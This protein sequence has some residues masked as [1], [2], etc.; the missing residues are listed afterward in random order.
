MFV[1]SKLYEQGKARGLRKQ[2]WALRKI[3]AELDVALSSVSVWVRDIPREPRR[4]HVVRLRRLS[5]AVQRCGRCRRFLPVEL[6]NKHRSN[7]RQ[8]W[9]RECFGGYFRAR[10]ALHRRQVKSSRQRRTQLA[11]DHVLKQLQ[12]APCAD[13]G[14]RDLVVLDYDHVRGDKVDDISRLINAGV[15]L[16]MLDEEIAKCEVVCANCHRLRTAERA[17]TWRSRWMRRETIENAQRPAWARNLNYVGA[18]LEL[19]GCVDCA[20]SDVRVLEFD[21]V[22]GTKSFCISTG[23]RGEVPLDALTAEM[24]KCEVRC[25]NCHRR[26]TAERAGF[27]R[28]RIINA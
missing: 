20:I 4:K 23:I 11:R 16:R 19:R 14:E 25:S 26:R 7:S 3:S 10:G 5:G 6:F 13:C 12:V 15:R 18:F 1:Q 17:D 22:I 8:Y 9:C 21:H 27:Y 28:H 24:S 2:G